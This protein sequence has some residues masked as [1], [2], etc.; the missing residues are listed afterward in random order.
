MSEEVLKRVEE[1][2]KRLAAVEGRLA[3]VEGRVPPPQHEHK[4]AD[5]K[6]GGGVF[7]VDCGERYFRL[8]SFDDLLRRLK[9]HHEGSDFLSCPSCRPKFTS[10]VKEL[11]YE[12]RD[13]GRRLEIRRRR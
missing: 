4:F 11:G 5:L 3:T 2:S 9:E 7:C 13:D 6:G 12:V 8:D 1:L 10:L